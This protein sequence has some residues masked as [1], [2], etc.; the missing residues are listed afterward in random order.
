MSRSLR[1][2]R[3]ALAEQAQAT[4]REVTRF[5][6]GGGKLGVVQAPPGS[7]KTWLLTDAVAG[8]TGVQGV[9]AGQLAA[10]AKAQGPFYMCK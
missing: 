3:S 2:R 4:S 1:D 8:I 5:V 9:T 7:G 10:A 6:T